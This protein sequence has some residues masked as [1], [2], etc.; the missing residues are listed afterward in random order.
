MAQQLRWLPALPE[1]SSLVASIPIRWFTAGFNSS[2]KISNTFFQLPHVLAH[3]WHS[4]TQTHSHVCV[5]AHTH[6][7]THT[8]TYTQIH[9]YTNTNTNKNKS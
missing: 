9:T 1:V 6:T 8:C 5:R 4:L 2:S 7:H 3:I